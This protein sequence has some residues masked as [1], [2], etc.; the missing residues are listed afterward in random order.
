MSTPSGRCGIATTALHMS[1]EN[2]VIEIAHL[3]LDAGADPNIRDDK[4]QATALGWARFFDRDDFAA[5]IS[6]W[7]GTT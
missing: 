7:G 4:Y 2:G 6:A 5:L 3:L 1:I